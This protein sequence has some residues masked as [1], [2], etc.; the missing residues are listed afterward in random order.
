VSCE[1]ARKRYIF[2]ESRYR[3]IVNSVFFFLFQYSVCGPSSSVRRTVL[4]VRGNMMTASRATIVSTIFKKYS[5][6]EFRTVDSVTA[7][8]QNRVLLTVLNSNY[9]SCY[10][11]YLQ[12]VHAG[13]HDTLCRYETDKIFTVFY[14]PNS[15]GFVMKGKQII[16]KPLKDSKLSIFQKF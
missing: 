7:A 4:P 1:I 6:S 15:Y 16:R 10:E 5:T 14:V 12:L 2:S 8:S 13:V 3:V 9:V 11:L